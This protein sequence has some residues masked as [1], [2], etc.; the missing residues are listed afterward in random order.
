MIPATMAAAKAADSKVIRYAFLGLGG[1]LLTGGVILVGRKIINSAISNKVEK[2]TLD[3]RS[4][5]TL[6]KQ[7]RMAFENN[8]W[9]GTNEE[10]VR[11]LFQNIPSKEFFYKRVVKAYK[12]LYRRNLLRDLADELA[13]TEYAEMMNILSP[14]PDRLF[15]GQQPKPNYDPYAWAKRLKAAFD[16]TYWGFPQ[17]DEEAIRAVIQE[18][19]NKKVWHEVENAYAQ[20]Y[21]RRLMTDMEDELD[22]W[23]MKEFMDMINAKDV[24]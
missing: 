7:F 24:V 22:R 12:Q 23:E 9:P 4:P 21:A 14:K 10:L 1:L 18:V 3:E 6:A 11:R 8:N 17:T 19:P 2:K 5:A 13:D 16:L 15:P 20:L